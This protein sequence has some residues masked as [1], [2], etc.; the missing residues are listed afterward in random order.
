MDNPKKILICGT[1]S[2]VIIGVIASANTILDRFTSNNGLAIQSNVQRAVNSNSDLSSSSIEQFK[3]Q[4]CGVDS[5]LNSNNYVTEY[6]L[7]HTC[8]MPLG[9]TVDNQAE[10]IWYVS[11]KEGTLGSYN[12]ITKRFDKEI[13]IPIWKVRKNPIDFSNV[14]SVKV[15]PIGGSVWFTDEKQN[16]IW[17]YSKSVGFD[18]YKVPD[19]S[20]IFGTTS[21]MALG[22]DSRGNV[23]FVGMHSPV[24]WF[25]NS[26]LMKNSTSNGITKIPM[27]VNNFKGI[28]S[29]QISI[30]SMTLDNRRN[31]IWISLSALESEGEILRYNITSR[32]FD[33][34]ILPEQ[35]SLPV[36]LAVDD[37]GNLWATDHGTSIFYMLNIKNHNVT[38]FAT[39]KASPRIYGLNDSSTLPGD[40]NTLPYW[41]EKDAVEGSLWFN[42]HQGNKIARF[43]PVNNILY[44]YWIP[45]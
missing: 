30:G 4:F 17:K 8:E 41:M 6:K 31:V 21:P 12:L 20:S 44:E 24:L 28:D 35:L 39:S 45:T 26:T 5:S 19:S 40:A 32:T 42:E 11:T 22:F 13:S 29:K 37:N 14:W 25:G 36:G 43:N 34:F 2:V 15:N 10:K 1:I 18:I 16:A 9:I 38:M 27:P 23:Y 7:P 33:T 3:N